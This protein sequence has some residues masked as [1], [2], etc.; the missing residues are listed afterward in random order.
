[1]QLKE[2]YYIA[3]NVCCRKSATKFVTEIKNSLISFGLYHAVEG[4]I[5]YCY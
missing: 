3:T 2:S 5:L 1:M 4:I